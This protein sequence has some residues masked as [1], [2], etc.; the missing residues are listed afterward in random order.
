VQTVAL[1]YANGDW[2]TVRWVQIETT[3]VLL[4]AG[5]APYQ[6]TAAPYP[7]ALQTNNWEPTVGNVTFSSGTFLMADGPY[8]D[9]TAV[10]G[11][12]CSTTGTGLTTVTASAATLPN[13]GAGF[14]STDVGRMI[15]MFNIPPYWLSGGYYNVG[16]VYTDPTDQNVYQCIQAITA[17]GTASNTAPSI[18][19]LYWTIAV[20]GFTWT[21]GVITQ[22][23]G[24]AQAQ[25]NILGPALLYDAAT[26]VQ[27]SAQVGSP[28]MQF[29]MGVYSNTTGWPS[30]GC[31]HEGRLWLGGAIPNRFDASYANGLLQGGSLSGYWSFAPTDDPKLASVF[32]GQVTDGN[33]I[34]Y[35]LNASGANQIYWMEPNLQ[36]IVCGTAS[37]EFLIQASNQN[38]VLTP[39]SIQAHKM[40]R[41]R[42]AD[43]APVN[44]GLT[45]IFVQR[46]QRR[47]IE[48]L[49]DVFS[50]KYFGPNLS[51]KAL[52]ITYSGVEELA[53]Q[54]TL[55]PIVWARLGDGSLAGV[56]YRRI[57]QFSTEPPK[58]NAW[59]SH[60]LGSGR[61]IT[62]ICAGPS[63]DTEDET[64]TMTTLDPLSGVYHVEVMQP[65]FEVEGDP[66]WLAWEL[67][68]AGAPAALTTVDAGAAVQATGLWWLEGEL[69]LAYVGGLSCGSYRVSGGAITIP[70]GSDPDG[71]F[72]RGYLAQL[73]TSGQSFGVAATTLDGVIS[74]PAI[75]GF[76]FTSQGKLL[77]PMEPLPAS[78]GPLL[79]KLRREHLFGLLI[80]GAVNGS[81]VVGSDLTKTMYPVKMNS[82]G[83]TPYQRNQ[84]WS[85]VARDTVQCDYDFDG[86]LAWQVTGPW[87]ATLAA[88]QSFVQAQDI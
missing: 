1:P 7:V 29:A 46:Y 37:G 78:N 35:T 8:L 61:L 74:V 6:I 16:D 27:N 69:V 68:D 67:D 32:T 49:S 22:V 30:N 65:Y 81:I 76:P 56:T 33:G 13:G 83:G 26:S 12:T 79:A 38:N 14:Q 25:V 40:T 54:E 64:L 23:F 53:Y 20:S 85:G 18:T 63:P 50:G 15:R 5:Y 66:L 58:F 87:P 3:L 70:Y 71:L 28:P 42:C 45:T 17:G 19:P 60:K 51:E 11:L 82:P 39:T 88:A 57:S 80:G 73:A 43:L 55:A 21:W 2:K 34:S 48:Y 84:L 10:G 4:H 86:G 44:T 59:H 9:F 72:T 47:L 75:V 52:D 31:Y 36:G 77:R 41:Y 62:S 24:T